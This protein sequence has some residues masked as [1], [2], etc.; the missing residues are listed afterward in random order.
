[1]QRSARPLI[2]LVVLMMWTGACA[3]DRDGAVASTT[4]T[5]ATRVDSAPAI[6]SIR[7]AT[8]TGAVAPAR[9]TAKPDR[10]AGTASTTANASADGA[11]G[12]RILKR[13]ASTYGAVRSMRADF[14]MHVENPLFKTSANSSGRLYQKKPDRI[15]LRFTQ[16]AGDMIVGDGTYF[17]V[18]TPSSMSKD[19]VLRTPAA[20]AGSNVVDLQAQF[21]GDP[22]KRFTYTIAGAETVNG[23]MTDVLTLVPRD[24]AQYRSLKVWIDRKDALVRK[25]TIEEQSG[26]RRTIQLNGLQINPAIDASIFR[27][28]PPAGVHVVGQ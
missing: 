15:A 17:W 25:F 14:T 26:V 18:Y 8:A 22:V 13:T 1:M 10:S 20:A 24:A 5:V 11:D 12:A 21:V 7:P 9:D 23:R 16:P 3:K 27:F 28:T 4:T 6:D 19:Q 2:A